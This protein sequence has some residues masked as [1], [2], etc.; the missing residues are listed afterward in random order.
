MD[1]DEDEDLE[2]ESDRSSETVVS[3]DQN[4]LCTDVCSLQ[5]EKLV[6]RVVLP[7]AGLCDTWKRASYAPADS[8]RR[9]LFSFAMLK[10]FGRRIFWNRR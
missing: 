2:I 4:S 7:Q 3:V 10:R 5:Y 9:K 1:H 8:R 6:I